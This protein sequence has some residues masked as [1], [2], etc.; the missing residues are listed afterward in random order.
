[1]VDEIPTTASTA[2][3]ITPDQL[4]QA[5]TKDTRLVV[6][7]SPSNPCGT[8]YEPDELLALGE[9]I[10]EAANTIAPELMLIS[11]ELYDRIVFDGHTHL[12]LGSVPELAE[13][14]ITVNGLSKSYAMTG[15]RVGYF[16]CP[17]ER[18]ARIVGAVKKLQSQS[19]TAIPTFI[20]PAIV[21]ALKECD[22]H[23]EQMRTEFQR[24]ARVAYEGMSAIPGV[25]C[26]APMGAFYLFP[27][28]S[29]HFGKYTPIGTT[30]D[31]GM[32]FA[33]ALLDEAHV[34]VVPGED[35]GTGGERCFRFTF[36][37]GEEQIRAGVARIA[38][39]VDSLR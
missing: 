5:I 4:R 25:V 2:F 23:V 15:W 32:S 34:A 12:S 35:F 36:A 6:L 16:A 7:N 1:M 39:F 31:N 19:T 37:C 13:R 33:G 30:I 17:G 21:A 28:V 24:R 10:I 11:D 26:P 29:A 20:M 9:V 14:T 27:D 38:S 8:M 18:G 3:K 22:A